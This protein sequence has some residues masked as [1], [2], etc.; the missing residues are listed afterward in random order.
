MK[1]VGY[2]SAG[3]I[4]AQDSLVDL[5]LP[6][7]APGSRDL[8]VVVKAISVNPADV[9]MRARVSPPDGEVRILGF[10]AAG[11]VDA[12]GPDV[13]LFKPGDEVFYA[14]AMD[15]PGTNSEFHLVDERVVGHKPKILSFS[16]AAALPLTSIAAWELLF[17]R[18]AVPYG[19]KSQTGALLII[20]GAGGVRAWAQSSM[21]PS[22]TTT[23]VALR[24]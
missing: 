1:A 23:G 15:R 3:P 10:D 14:A 8:R 2:W 7:P 5:E 22:T 6:A 18:L 20:N 21:M 24:R 17:E 19:V 9:Q 11:I 12:V 16:Q 4:S 13:T